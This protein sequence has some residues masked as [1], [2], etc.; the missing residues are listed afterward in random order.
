MSTSPSEIKNRVV[1]LSY[2]ARTSKN[3]EL[4]EDAKQRIYSIYHSVKTDNVNLI[5]YIQNHLTE[6]ESLQMH[7]RARTGSGASDIADMMEE[8]NTSYYMAQSLAIYVFFLLSIALYISSIN[9][10]LNNITF[11][12]N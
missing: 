12:K 9:N 7:T 3:P 2:V 4:A 11:R 10:S 1:G 6:I 5:N 8:A